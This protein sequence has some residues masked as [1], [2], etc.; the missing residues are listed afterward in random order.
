MFTNHLTTALIQQAICI[1]WTV[2]YTLHYACISA[3]TWHWDRDKHWLT[4]AAQFWFRIQK[5][6]PSVLH[7]LCMLYLHINPL[8]TSSPLLSSA[9]FNILAGMACLSCSY[10]SPTIGISTI[11]STVPSTCTTKDPCKPQAYTEYSTH[12][13]LMVRQSPPWQPSIRMA[14]ALCGHEQHLPLSHGYPMYFAHQKARWA[15][16]LL[17][18]NSWWKLLV[19]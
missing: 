11:P 5:D 1:P 12:T 3:H 16:H 4:F 14:D 8:S 19:T 15:H 13:H 18:Q 6:T 2:T 17:Q 7:D 10:L 9:S